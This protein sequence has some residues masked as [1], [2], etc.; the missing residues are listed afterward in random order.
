MSAVSVL[1]VKTPN[2][3]KLFVKFLMDLYKNNPYY[4][5]SFIKDEIKVWDAK[6]IPH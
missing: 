2:E 5:P 3:L 6:K 1:E 4:V